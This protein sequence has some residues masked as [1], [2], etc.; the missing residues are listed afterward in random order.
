MATT[1]PDNLYSP[2]STTAYDI[3][4][5]TAA[6][7]S[8]VQSALNNVRTG[9]QYRILTNAQRLALTG[10]DLYEGLKVHTSDTRMDWLYSN[11]RWY[12]EDGTVIPTSVVGATVDSNGIISPNAGVNTVRVNGVFSARY[13]VYECDFS[14][15]FS[16]AAGTSLRMAQGNVPYTGSFY[17][18]QRI[19]GSG[20]SVSGLSQNTSSWPG[21]GVAASFVQG[22]WTF[23]NPFQSGVKWINVDANSAPTI[24]FAI[25]RGFL[26]NQDSTQFDGFELTVSSQTI[27]S[28]GL[29]F[30]KIRGVA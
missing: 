7:Q 20:T 9:G 22:K 10:A 13:R 14:L 11:S 28:G 17:A 29:S 4:V 23:V 15:N 2:D 24:G 8:S 12:G 21:A 30:L 16:A 27:A 19:S 25:D 26:S 18:A 6:M 3:P 5:V 1:T